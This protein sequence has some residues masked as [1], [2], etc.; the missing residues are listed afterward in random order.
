MTSKTVIENLKKLLANSYTLYLK[1]QNFHWN[2]TGP[3]F[4]SFHLL[5]EEQYTELALAVDT[6]AERIRALGEKAPGRYTTY[7][8]LTNINEGDENTDAIE[9]VKI[10][11]ADHRIVLDSL[12]KTLKAAQEAGDEGTVALVSE[13]ISIH[14]KTA[15]MLDSSVS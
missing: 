10:L 13:R 11:A 5:F 9:M 1:T 3:H 2:V 12:N 8:K 7:G 6:I 15:W 14:E 4:K